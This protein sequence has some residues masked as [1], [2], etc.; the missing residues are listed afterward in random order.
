MLT[1][2]CEFRLQF[3]FFLKQFFYNLE[4]LQIIENLNVEEGGE[5]CRVYTE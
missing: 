3:R 5:G 2:Y 1:G 4:W